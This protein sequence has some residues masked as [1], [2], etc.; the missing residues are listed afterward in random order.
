MSSEKKFRKKFRPNPWESSRV[1]CMR[2]IMGKKKKKKRNRKVT[3]FTASSPLPVVWASRSH[4]IVAGA[5]GELAPGA[6]PRDAVS[7]PGC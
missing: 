7:D 5:V 2:W 3:H 1:A 6:G 4:S